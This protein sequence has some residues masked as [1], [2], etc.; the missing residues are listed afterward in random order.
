VWKGN[1]KVVKKVVKLW[2]DKKV[3]KSCGKKVGPHQSCEKKFKAVKR[4]KV[5]KSCQVVK[6]NNKSCDMKSKNVVNKL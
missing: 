1:N 6:R 4:T 2:K 3:V 5:V